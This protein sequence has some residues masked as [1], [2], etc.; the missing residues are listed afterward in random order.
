MN[1]DLSQTIA[2]LARTPATLNE[3]LR[4][5]PDSWTF[6]TEGPGTWTAFDIVG[7]LIHAEHTDWIP[8]ASMI[9]Q[10]GESQTF[11]PFNREGQNEAVRQAP[12]RS[13]IPVGMD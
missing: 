11:K 6:S 5:L 9:L 1:H 13:G 2:L 12:Q 3:L 10:H 4:D 7:H 8:R